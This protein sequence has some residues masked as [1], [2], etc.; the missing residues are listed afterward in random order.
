MI[1]YKS[2]EMDTLKEKRY[3]ILWIPHRNLFLKL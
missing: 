3:M 2:N 1:I